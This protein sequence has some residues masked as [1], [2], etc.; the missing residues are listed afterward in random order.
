MNVFSSCLV[1]LCV[2]LLLKTILPLSCI[3]CVCVC[4]LHRVS[5]IRTILVSSV[6]T[7]L[8]LVPVNTCALF[9]SV[10]VS[11]WWVTRHLWMK[12]TPS[13]LF[14][15]AWR[16]LWLCACML[17]FLRA[18]GGRGDADLEAGLLHSSCSTEQQNG[19][20]AVWSLPH[21]WLA[22]ALR[23][24]WRWVSLLGTC[25]WHYSSTYWCMGWFREKL[26]FLI[27]SSVSRSLPT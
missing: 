9:S 7:R 23:A 5:S 19:D 8:S 3:A 22:Q 26:S 11:P 27:P 2:C 24:D 20:P 12:I 16:I 17:S 10:P 21:A 25:L 15:W 18:S 4:A 13:T 14:F 1:F 6:G